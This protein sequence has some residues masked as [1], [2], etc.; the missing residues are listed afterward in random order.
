MN[1]RCPPNTLPKF[2]QLLYRK[3]EIAKQITTKN[4]HNILPTDQGRGPGVAPGSPNSE[5]VVVCSEVSKSRGAMAWEF[6]NTRR[7]LE[8]SWGKASDKILRQAS[9]EYSENSP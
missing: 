5:Q 4:S 7:Q 2:L 6:H 3:P 8:R 9:K 1:I